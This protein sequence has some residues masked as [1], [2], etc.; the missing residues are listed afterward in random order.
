[1]RLI[2]FNLVLIVFLSCGKD[3]TRTSADALTLPV[4]TT[5]IRPLFSR[6]RN[7]SGGPVLNLLNGDFNRSRNIPITIN[8][9]ATCDCFV[10]VTGNESSGTIRLSQCFNRAG[11]FEDYD[12][13]KLNGYIPYSKTGFNLRL[14]CFDTP[15]CGSYR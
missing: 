13:E 4:E 15:L 7:I 14:T 2:F 12:C 9:L 1:M 3:E 10:F 6:W 8:V 5:S 11:H